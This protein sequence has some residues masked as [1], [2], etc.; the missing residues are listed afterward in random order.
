MQYVPLKPDDIIID[1]SKVTAGYFSGGLGTLAG[2]SLT[3]ASLSATQNKYYLN[4]QYSSEDHFSCLYGHKGGSGSSI[5]ATNA[6]IGETR[7]IYNSYASYLLRSADIEGGF[8]L[9]GTDNTDSTTEDLEVYI[10]MLERAKMKDKLNEGNWTLVLSGSNTGTTGVEL[11]LTDDSKVNKA[12]G[13]PVGN[14][15]SIYSGSNGTLSSSLHPGTKFGEVYPNV[16]CIVLSATALSSSIPGKDPNGTSG[17]I[18]PADSYAGFKSDLRNTGVANNAMKLV[19]TIMKS[20]KNQVFRS[21]E[22]Q[23]TVTYFC[24]ALAN[25]FNHSSHPTFTTGSE[26]E[27]KQSSFVGNPQTFISTI[28]LYNGRNDLVAVGRLSKMLSKNYSTE[29]TIK[30]KLTY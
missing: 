16:G 24:R 23:T 26:G 10:L 22:V 1:S 27:Y 20:G 13:S 19:N 11:K 30:V 29:A 28:G 21:E 9:Q 7:A 2:S 8:K 25:Q 14:K 15:F 4:L 6:G 3:T 5:A 17:S 12:V 18:S